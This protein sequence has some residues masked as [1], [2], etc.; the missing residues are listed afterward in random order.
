MEVNVLK[1][2]RYCTYE[3]WFTYP[4]VVPILPD[5]PKEKSKIQRQI[6]HHIQMFQ[7]R[8]TRRIQVDECYEE[9]RY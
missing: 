6:L 2:P 4:H 5:V 3:V 9:S 7:K 1:S 8:V